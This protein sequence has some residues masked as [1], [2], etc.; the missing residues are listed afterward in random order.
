MPCIESFEGTISVALSAHI[1]MRQFLW[2]SDL[3]Q[4]VRIVIESLDCF[5]AALLPPGQASGV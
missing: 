1:T 4:L 5:A 3:L 2:R